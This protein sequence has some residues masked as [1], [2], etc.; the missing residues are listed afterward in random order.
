MYMTIHLHVSEVN[1]AIALFSGAAT[2]IQQ[3][4]EQQAMAQAQAAQNPETA[5]VPDPIHAEGGTD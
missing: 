5:E 3:Q 1:A 2:K 4:A